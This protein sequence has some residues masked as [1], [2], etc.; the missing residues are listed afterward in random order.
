[1]PAAPTPSPGAAVLIVDLLVPPLGL[2]FFFSLFFFGGNRGYT[3]HCTRVTPCVRQSASLEVAVTLDETSR[4]LIANDVFDGLYHR[5]LLP[6]R[7]D[8]D[9]LP[10][11]CPARTPLVVLGDDD[12]DAGPAMAPARYNDFDIVLIRF[13]PLAG[14]NAATTVPHPAI[15]IALLKPF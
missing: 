7:F 2:N 5:L 4:G 6:D 1:M 12:A 9:E 15:Y 8:C 3:R 11:R 14:T 13:V 10:R